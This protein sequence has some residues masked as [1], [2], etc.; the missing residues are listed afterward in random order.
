MRENAQK[1]G[2]FMEDNAPMAITPKN[3]DLKEP[4]LR[5]CDD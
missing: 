1:S 5:P 4:K 2:I 3:N